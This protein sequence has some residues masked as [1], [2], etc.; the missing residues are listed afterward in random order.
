MNAAGTVIIVA[1]IGTWFADSARSA[2][3]HGMPP[4][5]AEAYLA[6]HAQCDPP[7]EAVFSDEYLTVVDIDDD[8]D[9]DYVL[10]GD[11]ASCVE[12]GRV[13][14][15]GGG[16]GVTSFKI[17]MRTGDTVTEVLDVFTQGA[18]IRAHKGFATVKTL[19]GSYRIDNGK[20]AKAKPSG[21]GRVVYTLGR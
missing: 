6:W 3:A 5:V 13:V 16:N 12:N 9:D 11:G 7:S 18:E 20:A 8:G 2:A 15:R 10:N 21:E 1:L 17:I 19:E 14:A 4:A